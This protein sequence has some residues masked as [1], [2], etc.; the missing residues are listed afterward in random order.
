MKK[1]AALFEVTDIQLSDYIL[2]LIPE[3]LNELTTSILYQ[4]LEITAIDLTKPDKLALLEWIVPRWSEKI[5][6]EFGDGV[7]N[8]TFLP[9]VDNEMTVAKFIRY[10]LGHPDKRVR[11]RAAHSL[12]RFASLKKMAVINHLIAQQDDKNCGQ[13]QYTE[14]PFYWLSAKLFLWISIE[15]IAKE[16]GGI[17]FPYSGNLIKELK[18]KELPHAQIKY[19]IKSACEELIKQ[20]KTIFNT[21]ALDVINKTLVCKLIPKP[22]VKPP[23]RG[24]YRRGDITTKFKFDMMDT[25]PYWYSSL[26]E[27]LDCTTN[28]VLLRADKFITTHWGYTG[29]TREN[30]PGASGDWGLRSNRHGSEPTIENL[31]TYFEYHAMFCAAGELLETREVVD[32]PEKYRNWKEWI[33]GWALCWDDFWL[34]DFRDPLPLLPKLWMNRKSEPDWEWGIQLDDFDKTVGLKDAEDDSY[35]TIYLGMRVQYGKDSESIS[36]TSALVDPKYASS[37]LKALQTSE[38]LDHYIPFEKDRDYDDDEKDKR[39]RL[40]GW[41]KRITTE[42]E[43]IDDNDEL[44]QDIDRSRLMPGSEFHKWAQLKL[45]DDYRF[46]YQGNDPADW[47]TWFETWNNHKKEEYYGSFSASGSRLLIKKSVLLDYLKA[48]NQCLILDCGIRRRVERTERYEYYPDY[49]YIYIIHS[50]GKVESISR[51]YQLR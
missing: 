15:R 13:F 42:R 3:Y 40:K 47:V 25:V 9:P 31:H 39:F 8:E 27:A 37:L 10:N 23:S 2:K 48:T 34:S 12:R 32:D 36:V 43:G 29:N 44:F 51:D 18:N 5:K 7:W 26:A 1:H 33:K 49:T 38:R 17:L 41:I 21:E 19:F 28:D 11:W 30:D 24:S 16:N 4:L 46:S 45:S 35:M 50:N 22:A 20:V 6:D 14:F